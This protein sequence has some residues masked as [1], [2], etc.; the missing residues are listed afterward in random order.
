VYLGAKRRYINTLPFL[1]F[2]R[3]FVG[4]NVISRRTSSSDQTSSSVRDESTVRDDAGDGHA[5][6]CTFTHEFHLVVKELAE[7]VCDK[8]HRSRCVVVVTT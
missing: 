4:D 3:D 7:V 1:S 8:S 2:I 6:R 5:V